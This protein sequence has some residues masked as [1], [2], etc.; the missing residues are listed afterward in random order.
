MCSLVRNFYRPPLLG[1]KKLDNGQTTIASRLSRLLES[2]TSVAET[3]VQVPE[4]IGTKLSGG[5][6]WRAPGVDRGFD[7]RRSS[8]KRA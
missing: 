8:F 5:E 6:S 3:K 1:G 2:L 7:A 4:K